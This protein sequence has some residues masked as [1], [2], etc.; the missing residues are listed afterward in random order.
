MG[1]T[2]QEVGGMSAWEYSACLA[3]W[4]RAHGGGAR[5]GK[6]REMTDEEMRAAGVVGF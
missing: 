2:P 3:G 5:D 6:G 1:F 4:A